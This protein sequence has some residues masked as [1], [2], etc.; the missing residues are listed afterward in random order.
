M[1]ACATDGRRCRVR[2]H[3][4]SR[5]GALA[6]PR[7]VTV[8]RGLSHGEFFRRYTP[9]VGHYFALTELALLVAR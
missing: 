9:Q 7:T 6:N 8:L 5:A 4:T 2:S 1:I 3:L